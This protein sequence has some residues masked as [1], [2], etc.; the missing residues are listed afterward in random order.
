MIDIV[1]GLGYDCIPLITEW[2]FLTLPLATSIF[3]IRTINIRDGDALTEAKR[4]LTST[5]TIIAPITAT[6]VTTTITSWSRIQ[7]N[8]T[9]LERWLSKD[10]RPFLDL[11]IKTP[12]LRR[13][14]RILIIRQIHNIFIASHDCDNWTIP[15]RIDWLR[16][17]ILLLKLQVGRD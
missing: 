2:L 8:L 3:I 12:S 4:R 11:L 10:G 16:L 17:L 1:L 6:Q 7:S 14:T 13:V 5:S 9:L 15:L